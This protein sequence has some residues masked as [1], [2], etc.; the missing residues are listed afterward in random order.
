MAKPIPASAPAD[1]GDLVFS[2]PDPS[3]HSSL[4]RKGKGS[5]PS[6][7]W[8]SPPPAQPARGGRR[9]PRRL[10][11]LAERAKGLR[12]VGVEQHDE[13]VAVRNRSACRRKRRVSD[14]GIRFRY[15]HHVVVV[16]ACP[17]KGH[18][19][20]LGCGRADS[21]AARSATR[22]AGP[23]GAIVSVSATIIRIGQRML[24]AFLT[25]RCAPIPSRER[26]ATR[27]CQSVPLGE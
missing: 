24:A 17:C 18:S 12:P 15:T 13:P 20:R 27:L 25:G 11:L 19:D 10:S 4:Q 14:A 26:A 6:P 23:I 5:T 16:L 8:P 9:R 7:P 21:L 2:D 22:S 3:L 1:K